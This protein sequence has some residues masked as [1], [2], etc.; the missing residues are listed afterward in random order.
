[1]RGMAARLLLA[2]ALAVLCV[3]GAAAQ[4]RSEAGDQ[5]RCFGAAARDPHVP[6]HNPRLR[7]MVG[8]TPAKGPK[9]F[10]APCAPFERV[11][12]VGVCEFGTPAAEATG[13]VA[14][15]GDSHAAHW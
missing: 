5:P 7:P 9:A 1:M 12:Q 14:L 8:P 2:L 11:G 15:L 6:C 10:N 13:T 4:P 3:Q